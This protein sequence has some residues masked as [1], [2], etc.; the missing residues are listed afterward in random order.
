MHCKPL[1]IDY[2]MYMY[3]FVLFF[4]FL[5]RVVQKPVNINESFTSN[6]KT[7]LME[8]HA[9][10]PCGALF[11]LYFELGAWYCNAPLYSLYRHLSIVLS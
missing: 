5:D 11:V 2:V 9:F 4:F 3:A 6:C 10:L 1:V 7:Q 8:H